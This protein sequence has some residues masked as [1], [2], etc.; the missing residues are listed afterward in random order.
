[1]KGEKILRASDGYSVETVTMSKYVAEY[2]QVWKWMVE[3]LS[4]F[5][6]RGIKIGRVNSICVAK[7]LIFLNI[8]RAVAR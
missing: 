5:Q 3:F 2:E 1:M 7:P 6:G 4:K 8:L